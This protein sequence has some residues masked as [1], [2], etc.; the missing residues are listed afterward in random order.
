MDYDGSTRAAALALLAQYGD[1]AEVIAMLRAAEFAAAGDV[2]GLAQWD[3]ILGCL[4][5][6]GEDAHRSRDLN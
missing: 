6:M 4:A 5:R 3:D 1:D 2:D